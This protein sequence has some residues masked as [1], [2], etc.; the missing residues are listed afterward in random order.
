MFIE[1]DTLWLFALASA[2]IIVVPG[3]TVTVIVANSLR[4]GQQAGLYNV[5]GTQ[6]GLALMLLVLSFGFSAV[7]NQLA[8]LFNWVRIA[9]AA[10]LIWLGVQLWRANGGTLNDDDQTRRH[11]SATAFVWQGFIVIWSNP[12]ALFFFGAFLPQFV[13]PS[14]ALMPQLMTLGITFMLIGA[15]LDGAYAVA[16]GKAGSWLT[17]QKVI[18][19]ER[20]SGTFL[21]AGGVWLLLAR[22]V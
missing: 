17:R 5:L 16:A 21:L 8:W 15:L 13:D 14:A 3:P 6:I 2:A 22:R 20:A 18:W 11:K 1:P 19:V 12:K 9:G 7:V 4:N 10:Y